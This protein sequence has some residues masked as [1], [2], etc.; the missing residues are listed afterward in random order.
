MDRHRHQRPRLQ[1]RPRLPPARRRR[2]HR[3]APRVRHRA[4]GRAAAWRSP[5][6]SAATSRRWTSRR[7]PSARAWRSTPATPRCSTPRASR[8]RVRE[9]LALI[10]QTLDEAL[11]EQEGDFDADSRWALTWFEQSGFAEGEYGVAEQLSK[12]K[13]TSVAGMVEAGI[14]ESKRGKVRLLR[15]TSC[16]SRLGPGHRP[17]A[18]RLGDGPSLD[19]RARGQTAKQERPRL[20]RS[21]APRPR[22]RASSPTASTPL[23]AQEAGRGSALLQ[24]PGAGWPEID[25]AR[26]RGCRIPSRHVRR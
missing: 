19:P 8:S 13:N 6:S 26:A 22:S 9:A 17:A 18:D 3:H 25:A 16:P 24:R 11:A 7:R 10:N 2:A 23:R 21:S 4:Q 12:S 15:P 5:T 1:H 14:L 20:S